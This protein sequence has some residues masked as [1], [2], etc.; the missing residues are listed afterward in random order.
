MWRAVVALCTVGGNSVAFCMAGEA[1]SYLSAMIVGSCSGLVKV[2]AQTLAEVVKNPGWTAIVQSRKYR[3]CRPTG[4]YQR[5]R[6]LRLP[7]PAPPVAGAGTGDPLAFWNRPAA[8][9]DTRE[10]VHYRLPVKVFER[11][12]RAELCLR[13]SARWVY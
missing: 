7:L 8:I 5:L 4:R 3:K 1:F 11:S 12:E 10:T 2:H 6:S 13:K 9:C